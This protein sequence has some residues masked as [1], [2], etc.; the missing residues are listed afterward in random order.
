MGCAACRC[1]STN[2]IPSSSQMEDEVP[3]PPHRPLGLALRD[4]AALLPKSSLDWAEALEEAS[5]NLQLAVDRNPGEHAMRFIA[6]SNG[7]ARRAL[8]VGSHNV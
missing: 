3:D 8:G 6:L 7:R 5:M 2:R 1:N 4:L